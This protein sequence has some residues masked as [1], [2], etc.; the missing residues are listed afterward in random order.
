MNK[1]LVYILAGALL[2]YALA[3]FKKKKRGRV[4]VDRIDKISEKQFKTGIGQIPEIF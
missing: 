4:V 3:N 2:G 1:N